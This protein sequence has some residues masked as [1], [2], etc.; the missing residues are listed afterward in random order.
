MDKG[1]HAVHGVTKSR[2]RQ[3]QLSVRTHVNM[4]ATSPLAIYLSVDT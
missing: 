4:H 3:E 1:V 2:T